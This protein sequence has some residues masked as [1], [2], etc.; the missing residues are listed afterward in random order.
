MFY[1]CYF[2]AFFP[3]FIEMV[4]AGRVQIKTGASISNN[5]LHFVWQ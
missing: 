4:T 1:V 3:T 2:N 5:I